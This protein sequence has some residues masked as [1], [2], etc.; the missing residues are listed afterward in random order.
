MR[1]RGEHVPDNC[2]RVTVV[3]TQL[4]TRA[5][6]RI[7]IICTTPIFRCAMSLCCWL[8]LVGRAA[9][10][11]SLLHIRCELFVART[12][13]RR[14]WA[15]DEVCAYVEYGHFGRPL[16]ALKT[17]AIYAQIQRRAPHRF[18]LAIFFSN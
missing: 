7:H 8:L 2:A 12:N 3:V 18:A 5:A 16:S 6:I 4:H 9:E 14:R 11:I 15:D 17:D 10:L 13:R 1:A